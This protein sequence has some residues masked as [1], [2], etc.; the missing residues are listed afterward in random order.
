[1][2]HTINKSPGESDKLKTCLRFTRDSDA[3][4]LME[5]AVYAALADS[6]FAQLLKGASSTTTFY[7]L[8]PDLA[9]RGLL[10]RGINPDIRQIE[11]SGFVRLVTENDI[12]QSW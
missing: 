5:N 10:N 11:Y 6:E 12:V 1:M 4:L 8:T 3:V 7:V 2:L 9:A